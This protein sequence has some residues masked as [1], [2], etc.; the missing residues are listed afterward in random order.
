MLFLVLKVIGRRVRLA[1]TLRALGLLSWL[2]PA[3]NVVLL[4][5]YYP[6][7]PSQYALFQLGIAAVAAAAAVAVLASVRREPR[8]AVFT[9]GWAGTVLV[10]VAGFMAISAATSRQRGQPNV[11]LNLQAPLAG[12]AGRAES[13]EDY[14]G[15]VRQASEAGAQAPPAKLGRENPKPAGLEP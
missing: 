10:F 14:L 8:S 15:A 1:D 12:Y 9:L 2:V 6:L 7:S 4:V 13:F 5:A 3:T 11:D